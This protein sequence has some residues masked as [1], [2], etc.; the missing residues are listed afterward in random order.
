M[1]YTANNILH[2]NED[3]ED[4]VHM[5]FESIA[6][7]IEKIT[8]ADRPETRSYVVIIAERKSFD[9]LK[10]QSKWLNPKNWTEEFNLCPTQK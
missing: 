8:D 6:K 1:Y 2:N 5:A 3:A 10:H 9:M 7:N 4:A